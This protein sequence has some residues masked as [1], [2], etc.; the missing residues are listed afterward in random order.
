MR[1]PIPTTPPARTAAATASGISSTPTCR[2]SRSVRSLPRRAIDRIVQRAD[3]IPLYAEEMA[4]IPPA[5]AQG[6]DI[7]ISLSYLLL[8]RL[9]SVPQARRILHLAATIGRKFE[10][11]LLHRVSALEKPA[12]ESI[13]IGRASCRERVCQYV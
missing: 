6:D 10:Q 9:D 8:T 1:S 12:L 7:P 3:G 4:Q 2:A 11:G 5:A 13:Q